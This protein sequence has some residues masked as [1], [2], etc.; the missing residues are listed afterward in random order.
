[1]SCRGQKH[2]SCPFTRGSQTDENSEP[3]KTRDKVFVSDLVVQETWHALRHHYQ[4]PVREAAGCL[5]DFL[6]S[7]IV[8]G[9]GHA[10]SVLQG[11]SGSGPGVADRK[12]RRDYLAHASTTLTFDK[13]FSKLSHVKAL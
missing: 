5:A 6:A 4:V 8:A 13:E 12:I 2:S 10:L 11:Y 1:M 7:G 9:T 3:W